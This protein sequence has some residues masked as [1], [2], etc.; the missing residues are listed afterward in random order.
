MNEYI[1]KNVKLWK[2]IELIDVSRISRIK[3][4]KITE[5]CKE[6]NVRWFSL[7]GQEVY[8]FVLNIWKNK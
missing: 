1:I 6:K 3:V 8:K 7:F 2:Y 5:K 4:V